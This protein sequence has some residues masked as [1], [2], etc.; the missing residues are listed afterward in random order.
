MN[1]FDNNIIAPLGVFW[2][3]DPVSELEQ[4]RAVMTSSPKVA[5]YSLS[6]LKNTTDD[7][8]P[9]YLTSLKVV[10]NHNHT[11][12]RLLLGYLAVVVSGVTFYFDYTLGFDKTKYWT[13]WAVAAYFVLNGL[14][15]WWIWRVEKGIVFQGSVKGQKLLLYSRTEKHIP[16]Y[17]LTARYTSPS[18]PSLWQEVQL[19][20]PFT[21]WFTADGFFVAK[22]FQQWLASEIP[23]IGQADPGNVVEEIGRGDGSARAMNVQPG[24][25]EQVLDGLKD[26]SGRM[27]GAQGARSRRKV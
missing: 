20:A 17:H 4:R 11:D 12:V 10:Q 18:A 16:I 25:V 27:A 13:A 23:P 2:S 7:A 19:Q 9:N 1:T 8:L 22:P 14:F 24:R 3:L 21:R 15:T 26:A 6:D 5:V